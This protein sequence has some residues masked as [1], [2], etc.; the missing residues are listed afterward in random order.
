[1]DADKPDLVEQIILTVGFLALLAVCIL[2]VI[3]S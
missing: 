3:Y 1:M 2:G